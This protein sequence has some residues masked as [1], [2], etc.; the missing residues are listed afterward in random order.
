M[1]RLWLLLLTLALPALGKPTTFIRTA[2]D[3]Q[4]QPASMQVSISRYAGPGYTVDLV[5]AVHVGEKSY[6]QALNQAFKAYD[7]VLFELIA[8]PEVAEER[9]EA[10]RAGLPSGFYGRDSSNP[11]AAMQTMLCD[12]LS[13]QYQLELVEY[14]APNFVH[15]DLT[16]AEFAKSWKD[17]KESVQQLI[18]KL[19]Q[20][21]LDEPE[22]AENPAL[23]ELSLFGI[24]T[25]GPNERE[26]ILL[27]QVFAVSFEHLDKFNEVL[28]GKNG[29]TIVSARND[30]ALKVMAQQVRKGK[31]RLAIFYGAAHLPDMEKKLTAKGKHKLKSQRWMVAWDLRLPAKKKAKKAS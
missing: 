25:R 23:E 29:S 15:A 17:R 27:R 9:K 2:R 1:T 31:K 24:M 19:F 3:A 7:A 20:L 16:P 5:A 18:V 8:D 13:L 11:L 30:R 26:K 4:G 14:G 12:L 22:L 6:Y 28:N 21:S 10:Y